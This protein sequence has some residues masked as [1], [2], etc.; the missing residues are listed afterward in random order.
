M[1]AEVATWVAEAE[2]TLVVVVA[3]V[4]TSAAV[5]EAAA[6]AAAATLVAG[7]SAAAMSVEHLPAGSAAAAPAFLT[8]AGE[9]F[10][11]RPQ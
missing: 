3:E 1:A 4:G 9:P 11:A 2:V 8:E 10:S 6:S 5:V 7:K